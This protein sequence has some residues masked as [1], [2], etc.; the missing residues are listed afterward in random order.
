ME[1]CCI[2][3]NEMQGEGIQQDI[4]PILF[5]ASVCTREECLS[6][7]PASFRLIAYIFRYFCQ[8]TKNVRGEE[9]LQSH[10]TCRRVWGGAFFIFPFYRNWSFSSSCPVDYT[11]YFVKYWGFLFVSVQCLLLGVFLVKSKCKYCKASIIPKF[12]TVLLWKDS[13][14][15]EPKRRGHFEALQ[16]LDGLK[17][18]KPIVFV[19]CIE[20]ND[21]QVDLT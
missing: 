3:C 17:H 18:H 19:L 1:S 12:S 16:S 4:S 13:S 2:L 6:S 15:L 7:S 10:W 11:N 21:C 5:R 8:H 20:F 9:V 14:P